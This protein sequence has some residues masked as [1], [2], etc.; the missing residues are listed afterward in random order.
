[1]DLANLF[2]KCYSPIFVNEFYSG[3]L[4][5]SDEYENPFTFNHKVLYIFIDGRER[6]IIEFDLG[7]LI[8]CEFYGD[9]F[10]AP[11]HYQ[12]DNVWDT[13]ARELGCK[14][15][16]FD[17]K[18]LPLRFLHHFIASSV[19]CRIGAFTKLTTDDI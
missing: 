2:E 3:L 9:V 19:Q 18:S 13:M 4:L 5:R 16:A 14:K 8:G 12:I 6:I 17:L 10:E 15:V 7:K 11:K 1:M